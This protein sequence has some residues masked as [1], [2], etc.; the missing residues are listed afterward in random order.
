MEPNEHEPV[1]IGN[2]HGENELLPRT[3]IREKR[4]LDATHEAA[5]AGNE[6]SEHP[7]LGGIES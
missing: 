6:A 3:P 4:S 5:F 7:Q 1:A 2:L